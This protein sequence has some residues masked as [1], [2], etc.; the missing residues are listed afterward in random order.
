MV[1]KGSFVDLHRIVLPADERMNSL[2]ED[3]RAV[4]VELKIKGTLTV[5]A[6]IGDIVEVI[7]PAGRQ[8]SGTLMAENPSYTHQY[9][10]PIPELQTIG[11]ELRAILAEYQQKQESEAQS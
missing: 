3:T 6:E 9:G 1:K 2:P 10:R 7:T 5:D 4:D 8:V 11:I